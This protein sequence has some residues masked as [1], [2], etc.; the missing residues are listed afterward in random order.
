MAWKGRFLVVGFPAGIPK[1]PLNLPL[2]K[3]TQIV[4]VFWGASVFREPAG[5]AQNMKELFEMY[6]AGQVKPRISAH[7][8][9]EKA[10]EAL[11][12]MQDRKV[13]GKIVLRVD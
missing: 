10:A 2:L 4:G 5:H 8:P 6:A 9:L 11:Q 3:G 12:M 13:M 1:I 7:F